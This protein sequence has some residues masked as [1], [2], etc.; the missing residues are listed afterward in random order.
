MSIRWYKTFIAVARYGSFAAAAQQIGLTQA[1]ISIQMSSLE[2]KLRSHPAD[3]NT[4]GEGSE[5][6][7]FQ[8]GT[9]QDQERSLNREGVC[10]SGVGKWACFKPSPPCS[11][12][13][14]GNYAARSRRGFLKDEGQYAQFATNAPRELRRY[15]FIV[16][17]RNRGLRS[18]GIATRQSRKAK[19]RD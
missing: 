1:A 15:E 7:F 6:V 19:I 2:G 9:P 16:M 8:G 11:L 12:R 14:A 13:R 3:R 4:A 18:F 10:W 17:R 5:A